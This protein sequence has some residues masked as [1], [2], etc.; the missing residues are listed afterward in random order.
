M[1]TWFERELNAV[2]RGAQRRSLEHSM[3]RLDR[4]QNAV[5]ERARSRKSQ[6]Q[7]LIREA[8]LQVVLLND[9]PVSECIPHADAILHG[10]GAPIR[11]LSLLGAFAIHAEEAGE[12]AM[13]A[14]Y[15]RSALGRAK[16]AGVN[17][18]AVATYGRI[19]KRIEAVPRR[20]V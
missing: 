7:E 18:A 4:L 11:A 15:L 5:E 20:R 2:L 9:R 3:R 16:Q 17:P 8:R 10:E 6:Y 13:A 14:T 19:L 12:R 1:R